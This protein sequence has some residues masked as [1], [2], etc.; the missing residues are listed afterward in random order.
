MKHALAVGDQC[1]DSHGKF[2]ERLGV[3][4]SVRKFPGFGMGELIKVYWRPVVRDG[5]VWQR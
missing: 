3:G 4:R 5:V 1:G 2:M